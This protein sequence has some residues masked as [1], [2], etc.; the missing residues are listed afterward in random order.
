LLN[1]ILRV[2]FSSSNHNTL[3]PPALAPTEIDHFWEVQHIVDII[4]PVIGENWYP[5][6]IGEFM[7]LST[8][9]ND[10]R[11][12]FQV[13]CTDN[14]TKKFIPYNQYLTNPFIRT[15]VNWNLQG[16]QFSTVE[17]SVK[18]LALEMKYRSSV[19]PHLTRHIG[20]ELCTLMGW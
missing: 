10:R 8:F 3:N 1:A 15:Y 14:Q 4:K 12:M 2:H 5:L 16:G 17:A 13:K 11:N 9:I 18:V 20:E 19:Y 7:D 6:A